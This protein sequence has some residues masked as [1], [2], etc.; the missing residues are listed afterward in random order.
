MSK[1]DHLHVR[2]SASRSKLTEQPFPDTALRPMYETIVD[3]CVGLYSGEQSHQRQPF[4]ITCK[5][6]LM[7]RRSSI[8]V[9][10]R[11]SLGNGSSIRYHCSSSNQNR[12]RRKF[13]ST[14]NQR[15]LANHQAFRQQHFYQVLTLTTK[16]R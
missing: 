16:P 11:T 9:L 7:I 1:V 4:L 13:H 2:R 3:G 6:S 14:T 10:T 5:R 12:L 15:L 8:R